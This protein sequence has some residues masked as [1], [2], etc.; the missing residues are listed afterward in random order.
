MSS[1]GLSP[2]A[3]AAVLAV[4]M[5]ASAFFSGVET[6]L[7][8]ISRIRLRTLLRREPHPRAA[9]LRRLL[10]RIEDPVL[11]CLI[12]NNLV[13]VS[14]SAVLTAALAA[15]YGDRGEFAA[16]AIA[17]VTMVIFC[18]IIP[19]TVYREYPERLSLASVRPLRA[20]MLLLAPAR[21]VL[22]AYSSLLDRLLPGR[23]RRAE[24]AVVGRE[25]MHHLMSAHPAA[26]Q[27]GRFTELLARCL[28]L[29]DTNLDT[30][31]TPWEKVDSLPRAADPATCRRLAAASGYSRLPVLGDDP[32][33]VQGWVLVRDLLLSATMRQDWRRI[34]DTLL[35]TCPRVDR[36]MSPWGLFE[37]MRWQRQQMAVVAD[38]DGNPLGLVT[39]EDL[40][41]VLIGSI[42]DEFDDDAESAAV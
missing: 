33:E 16:A 23:G 17:T 30:V 40:L 38:A 25:A 34:P 2:A 28:A 35:R 6:G 8:S 41:E 26:A 1:S 14:F 12:G 39:L 42:A 36:D 13:N 7:M 4:C 29:S 24:G 5:T 32:R 37:E 15:R 27:D 19:K 11:T 22:L 3:T 10:A 21:W 20:V 9:E 31:M 18:E